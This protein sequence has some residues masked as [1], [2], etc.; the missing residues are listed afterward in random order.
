[1][2]LDLI[3][4]GESDKALIAR[5]LEPTGL[6]PA[7]Q[8]AGGYTVAISLARSYLAVHGPHICICLDAEREEGSDRAENAGYKDT[9]S[10]LSRFREIEAA[11]ADVALA[12]DF[13]LVLFKPTLPGFCW[14]TLY[15]QVPT[16]SAI[17]R[18]E[19]IPPHTLADS[20]PDTLGPEVWNRASPILTN[21][22][23]NQ[24]LETPEFQRI[25]N[26]LELSSR[27]E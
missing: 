26:F 20:I 16:W 10:V 2:K 7:I 8:A 17:G 15:S 9:P 12:E 21:E 11:L 18:L 5:I 22:Q 6:Q 27:G 4:E 13:L 19:I 25:L 14:S 3:V 1:M 24:L 23:C